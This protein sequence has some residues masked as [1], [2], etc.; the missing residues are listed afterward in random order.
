VCLG[1]VIYDIFGQ[2]GNKPMP[3]EAGIEFQAY[4]TGF[5]PGVLI[6]RPFSMLTFGEIRIGYNFVRHRD[7]GVHEDE[8]G[9]GPGFSLGV[10]RYF[11]TSSGWFITIRSDLWFNKVDWRDGIGTTVN[12]QGTTD[13]VVLQ[14]TAMIGHA[15]A[16][17]DHGWILRPTL[18]G[19]VEINIKTKG[20]EV[21]EGLIGLVGVQLSKVLD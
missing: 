5:I 15:F 9:G 14:P 1:G 19:G 18:A 16:L 13:V 3:W 20:E 12:S 11:N 2:D 10:K 6:A 4:P 21:G 8:R 17:G 7:L